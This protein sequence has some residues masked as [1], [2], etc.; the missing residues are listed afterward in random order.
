MKTLLALCALLV[1]S[2][3]AA[4]DSIIRIVPT[5]KW[6]ITPPVC[7]FTVNGPIQ[8]LSP[9]GTVSGTL[10]LVLYMSPTKFP[11]PGA[12]PVAEH[13]LGQLG[14]QYQFDKVNAKVAANVPKLTGDFYFTVAVVEYTN[15]GWRV[16]AF[17]D[18]GLRKVKNGVF[19]TGKK[20]VIPK[21]T[22]LPPPAKLRNGTR[23]TFTTKATELL[24]Q[25]APP[26]QTTTEVAIQKGRNCRYTSPVGKTKAK[27]T[28]KPGRAKVRG[29]PVDIGKLKVDFAA[30]SGS[31]SQ[32]ESQFTLYFVT[33]NAGYYKRTDIAGSGR[34][35]AW[36]TFKMY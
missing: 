35:V 36:G 5:P 2:L 14:G 12:T 26:A 20:W 13:T 27:Y 17:V 4:A 11:A 29:V 6:R 32:T 3:P 9:A 7:Q 34:L 25:I 19:V 16:R 21:D 18:T 15:A 30:A 23:F 22:V 24:D 33:A 28:Y 8:N 31:T 1:M 10:K